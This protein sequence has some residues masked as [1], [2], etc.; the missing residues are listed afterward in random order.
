MWHTVML[1]MFNGTGRG[2]NLITFF[3]VNKV[4][5]NNMVTVQ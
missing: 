3:Y 4:D 2:F 1:S 5:V